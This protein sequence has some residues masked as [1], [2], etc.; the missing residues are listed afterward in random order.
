[1]AGVEREARV[2]GQQVED[3]VADRW[4][5]AWLRQVYENAKSVGFN[6]YQKP[7]PLTESDMHHVLKTGELPPA[8]PEEERVSDALGPLL[9][10]H[11]DAMS[12]KPSPGAVINAA[13]VR[14]RTHGAVATEATERLVRG[15]VADRL[16]SLLGV[17]A[18]SDPSLDA[19][20]A[21]AEHVIKHGGVAG[22]A[23]ALI[24]AT[25]RDAAL[26][27]AAAI[28]DTA[29][30]SFG[31]ASTPSRDYARDA[32][33]ACAERVRA[34]KSKP[35]PIPEG[36]MRDLEALGATR[37]QVLTHVSLEPIHDFGWA[38]QQMRAGKKV[39]RG[40]WQDSEAWSVSRAD[41]GSFWGRASVRQ[42]HW[43]HV[44]ATDWE[45]VE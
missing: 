20:L 14:L 36:T 31:S 18:P 15:Q 39:R 43:E 21:Q 6:G 7:E 34:L 33:R 28:L 16:W 41:D 35:A 17:K 10:P 3:E 22:A 38:L 5:R 44:L 13:S 8:N 9:W 29:A 45:V 4:I 27:E 23:M 40:G 32:S 11:W 42:L 1:M 2:S 12:P 24:Q 30:N 25:S 37:E 26:E 19:A